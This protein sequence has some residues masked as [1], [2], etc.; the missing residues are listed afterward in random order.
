[1][2]CS[3]EVTLKASY[4]F[5]KCEDVRAWLYTDGYK[6]NV[7]CGIFEKKKGISTEDVKSLISKTGFL[8]GGQRL[9]GA[10]L[11][12]KQLKIGEASIGND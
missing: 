1:V 4:D 5:R 7:A 12:F 2:T 11:A 8:I 6:Y 10:R 9:E 3:T